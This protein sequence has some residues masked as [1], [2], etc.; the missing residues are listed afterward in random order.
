MKDCDTIKKKS[1]LSMEIWKRIRREMDEKKISQSQMQRLC[2]EHGYQVSQPEISKLN[3]G[4]ISLTLYQLVAF[5][6]ALGVP[7]S[8][9]LDDTSRYDRF[10]H[11]GNGFIADPLDDA[12]QA[13]YGTYNTI[14]HSTSPF[15][16][17]LL[18]GKLSFMPNEKNG[19]CD[20]IFCLD[21]GEKNSKNQNIW[22]KYEGSLII[23]QR[24]S[25]AYCFLINERRG[26]INMIVFRH[27]N[28]FVKKMECRLGMVLTVA[29]GEARNPVAQKVFISR[30]PISEDIIKNITP[31]LKL[32]PA[33]EMV[34]SRRDLLK[35]GFSDILDST[36]DTDDYVIVNE[37]M[38][39][40]KNKRMSMREVARLLAKIKAYSLSHYH[41]IVDEKEDS[42]A[43]ELTQR[44]EDRNDLR[45]E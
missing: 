1:D 39:R 43:Y 22:K 41:V 34:V 16:E 45:A 23:S 19:R 25:V 31:Y 33:Q 15:E 17:K 14:L 27:K 12:Y 35:L 40:R 13:Y 2:A 7:A 42:L 37:S 10:R 29:S 4:K 44:K 18:F 9:F 20:A 6:E 11:S 24:L 30:N 21:T 36:I 38:L 32:E 8:Q 3:A 28:F 26:E 5:S